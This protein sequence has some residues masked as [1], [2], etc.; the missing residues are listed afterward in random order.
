MSE[1]QFRHFFLFILI[2][3]GDDIGKGADGQSPCPECSG[4]VVSTPGA[5]DAAVIGDVRKTKAR[6]EIT[7]RTVL[8]TGPSP[9]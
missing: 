5:H 8:W 6:N 2:V 9:S 1:A 7:G 4:D 3:F